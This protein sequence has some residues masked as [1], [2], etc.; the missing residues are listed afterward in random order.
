MKL[1]IV[2]LALIGAAGATSSFALADSGHHGR[3]HTNGKKDQACKRA[4]VFGTAAAPQS[5]TVTVTHADRHSPFHNGDVVTVSLG[6]Q[7]QTVAVSGVGCADGST[8]QANTALL[9]VRMV[10]VSLL[11]RPR[12]QRRPGIAARATITR[13]GRRRPRTQRRSRRR[14]PTRRHPT[15]RPPT[16]R[17][18]T[19]RPLRPRRPTA[20]PRRRTVCKNARPPEGRVTGREARHPDPRPPAR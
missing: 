20:R 12:R 9:H 6:A 17:P 18:L 8:L 1:K 13:V 16:P 14:H 4:V 15:P 10:R 7:G 5:F 11:T 2:L 19:R 3:G